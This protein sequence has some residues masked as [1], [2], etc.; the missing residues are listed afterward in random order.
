LFASRR[1]HTKFSRDW[2]SD[3]CSSD[4]TIYR[5]GGGKGFRVLGKVTQDMDTFQMPVEIKIETEGEPEFRVIEVAGRASDYSVEAFGKPA[6]KSGEQG[7][8]THLNAT[9][10]I[11]P[12]I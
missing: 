2:S 12:N 1:R 5:L 11:K 7:K 8:R 10:S 6:R 4:L 9:Y 3:V